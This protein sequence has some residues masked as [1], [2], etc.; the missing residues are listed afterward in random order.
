MRSHELLSEIGTCLISYAI[1]R[2][3]YLV[4]FLLTFEM[5][6]KYKVNINSQ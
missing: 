5:I 2:L 1:N 6:V 3:F 4:F